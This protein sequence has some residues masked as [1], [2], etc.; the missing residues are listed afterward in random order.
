M[1]HL[2]AQ[3]LME[4]YGRLG[5]VLNEVDVIIRTLPKAERSG[6]LRAL[7]DIMGDVWLRLQ[8]PIVRE[9]PTLDPDGDL[10]RNQTKDE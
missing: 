10:Y 7:S 6:H 1:D 8:L 5:E 3:K 2:T 4:T 9:Y